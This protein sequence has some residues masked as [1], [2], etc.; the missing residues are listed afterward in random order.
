MPERA[1]TPAAVAVITAQ[2]ERLAVAKE[3]WAAIVGIEGA[4]RLKRDEMLSLAWL[5]GE[6]L[7]FMKEEVG[8]G[9]WLRFLEGHWPQLG[10]RNAQRCMAFFVANPK[11]VDSTDLIF[12]VESIRKFLWDYIPV[13]ERPQ[14]EGD[15]PVAPINHHLGVIN[16]WSKW[17]RQVSLGING[18]K[19]PVDQMRRDFEPMIKSQV[20]LLGKEWLLEVIEHA[21]AGA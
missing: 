1:L 8:H 4:L 6:Q 9:R 12:S 16:H 15:A 19:P 2:A 17:A 18:A 10:E 7:V 20:E 13:K 14:L 3:I 21:A 11:S 5:L